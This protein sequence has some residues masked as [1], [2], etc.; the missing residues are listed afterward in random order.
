[1]KLLTKTSQLIYQ[2]VTSSALYSLLALALQQPCLKDIG[3]TNY[4][5]IVLKE[6]LI[7]E[8]SLPEQKQIITVSGGSPLYNKLSPL[9]VPSDVLPNQNRPLLQRSSP[10]DWLRSKT[11]SIPKRLKN[12]QFLRALRVRLTKP[13]KQNP[14]TLSSST[15]A[16]TWSTTV[17]TSDALML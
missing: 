14:A 1:M 11:L 3:S 12:C 16:L 7:A 9:G 2:S 15:F 10:M 17:F 6:I 4:W 13:K 5:D 8:S